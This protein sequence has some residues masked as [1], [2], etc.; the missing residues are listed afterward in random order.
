ATPDGEEGSVKL[1][2]KEGGE[3]GR[4]PFDC[5]ASRSTDRASFEESP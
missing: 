3:A 4:A 2:A 1:S 5:V